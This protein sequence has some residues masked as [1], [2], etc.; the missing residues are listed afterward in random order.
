[1]NKDL[2]IGIDTSAYTTS[3]CVIH[4][5]TMEIVFERRK[6]LD[7]AQGERGLRQNTA[8]FQHLKNLPYFIEELFQNMSSERIAC[9]SIT[10][11]PRCAEG[12]Y[13]PVFFAG[14]TYARVLAASLNVPLYRFSHQEGHI[15]AGLATL[16]EEISV[17]TFL[18]IHISGGTSEVCKV[19]KEGH[20]YA[21]DLL[22]G[23]KDLHAGQFVDR[24]GVK[25]G[26]SFPAGK[27][28]EYL[29]S[30]STE[31]VVLPSSVKGFDFS[32]SGPATKA[33]Q[34]IDLG[35]HAV[36]DIA[37]AVEN[38]IAKT[39]EKVILH[40]KEQLCIKHVL[41]VGGVAS[42]TRVREQ[43]VHRFSHRA[44][45]AHLYFADK[46]YSTDNAYGTSV[47]GALEHKSL[48]FL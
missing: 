23:T 11:R 47:L 28:L 48:N 39:L 16:I 7:V 37:R 8:V 10:N 35:Q 31:H 36:P 5:D 30:E 4:L 9:I 46:D 15:A 40:G 25:L 45:Q 6:L 17:D 1:M 26:L 19:N 13:M 41:I 20:R 18:A 3:L 44:M 42:N 12:S 14:E 34:L 21:I 27:Q 24:I 2:V 43:L 38:C 22:G 33:E 29:A 32:F